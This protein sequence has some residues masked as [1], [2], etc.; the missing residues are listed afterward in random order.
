MT[1]YHHGR[2]WTDKFPHVVGVI[3]TNYLDYARREAGGEVK[4]FFLAAFNRLVCRLHCHKAR[5]S[6]GAAWAATACACAPEQEW[7]C[8]NLPRMGAFFR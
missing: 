1:W 8:C 7:A 6:Q 2:R 4:A 3:H 5:S